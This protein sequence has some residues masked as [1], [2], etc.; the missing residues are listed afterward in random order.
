MTQGSAADGK[1]A[2]QNG[3]KTSNGG[4]DAMDIDGQVSTDCV[5]R[6]L[7]PPIQPSKQGWLRPSQHCQLTLCLLMHS[8]HCYVLS[9]PTWK[10]ALSGEG[11]P[12]TACGALR[13]GLSAAGDGGGASAAGRPV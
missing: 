12:P 3:T 6:E 7:S 2:A 1:E 10:P 5:A 11:R 8:L 4:A 13:T 9:K